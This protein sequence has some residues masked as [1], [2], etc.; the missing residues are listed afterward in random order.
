MDTPYNYEREGIGGW[1]WAERIPAEKVVTRQRRKTKDWG[2]KETDGRG[3]EERDLEFGRPAQCTLAQRTLEGRR[4]NNGRC[5]Q[6]EAE[7]E[8]SP[9]EAP[10]TN[11][12]CSA[13]QGTGT[14][15]SAP[16]LG[17]SPRSLAGRSDLDQQGI[18]CVG[19]V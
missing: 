1:I 10:G 14:T 5:H 16:P 7:A 11:G 2:G 13:R 15:P 12:R 3:E 18:L 4:A 19:F 6:E 8:A 17:G 9:A